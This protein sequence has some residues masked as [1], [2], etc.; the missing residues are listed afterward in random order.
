MMD[1]IFPPLGSIYLLILVGTKIVDAS[2]VIIL[3]SDLF[4][5]RLGIP[6][7]AFVNSVTSVV[8]KCLKFPHEGFVHV[9]HGT[10]YKSLV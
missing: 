8:H 5:V 4:Q 9:V 7:L 10:N 1:S 3:E 2:L 6:R